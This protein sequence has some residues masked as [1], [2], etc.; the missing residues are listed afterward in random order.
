MLRTNV[1]V[2]TTTPPGSGAQRCAQAG[3]RKHR[4]ARP[5]RPQARRRTRLNTIAAIC[6]AV[7]GF[8]NQ[9]RMSTAPS[10]LAVATRVS[11]GTA[12]ASA[13]ATSARP[14]NAAMQRGCIVAL[15]PTAGER[16]KSGPRSTEAGNGSVLRRRSLEV[17]IPRALNSASRATHQPPTVCAIGGGATPASVTCPL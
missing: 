10:A 16:P 9:S 1:V 14:V 12:V 11:I 2:G 7:R 4:T 3:E 17:P 15:P 8:P 6:V 13:N 5:A